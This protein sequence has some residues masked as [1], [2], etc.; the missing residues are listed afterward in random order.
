[1]KIDFNPYDYR[2]HTD[3]YP[4]YAQ[5]R[6][7]APVYRNQELGFWALSRHADV[8][9]AFRDADRFSSAHGVTLDPS[10]TGAHA[11]QVM[12]FLAMDP[13]EHG[14]LRGLV[15]KAFTVRRVAQLEPRVRA[16]ALQHVLPALEAARFD[17][18]GEV[19]GR[20]PMDVISEMLGVAAEDR[21]EL[22]QLADEVL[23][24]Q[25]GIN[26]VPPGALAAAVKL[27]SYYEALVAERRRRPGDDLTSALCAADIEGR[28]LSDEDVIAFLFLMVVAG[29]ETTAKLLGNC[30][31]WG[32]RFPSEGHKAFDDPRWIVPWIEE[33]LRFDTSSHILAR[34]ATVDVGLHGVTIP[35]GGRVVLL[36]ASANRDPRVFPDPDRYD[37]GRDTGEMLSFGVGRHFCLGASLARLEAR[38]VLEELGSRVARYEV[39]PDGAVRVH[40]SNVLGFS[41]LPTEVRLR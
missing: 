11:R 35:A 26:D 37:L 4:V 21:A 6:E 14:H 39:D 8:R 10:A 1:V 28:R 31:Y 7:E 36:P 16:I 30:W 32:W 19:A 2:W 5:L 20:I 22:R 38:V 9:D 12:S 25:P 41:A 17:L 3:P 27:V 18:I 40:S 29:N 13:P 33:T 15:S 23:H 34:T 24:R